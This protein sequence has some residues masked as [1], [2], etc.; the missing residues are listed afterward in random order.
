MPGERFLLL[1]RRIAVIADRLVVLGGLLA[2]LAR[3]PP[4]AVP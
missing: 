1:S 3:I 4:V 2:V